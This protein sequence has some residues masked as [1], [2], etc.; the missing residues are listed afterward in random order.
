MEE[1]DKKLLQI[2]SR[3]IK[4]ARKNIGISQLELANRC[5]KSQSYIGEIEGCKKFPS[6]K[7]L[8][9]LAEHLGIKPYILLLDENDR[10]SNDKEYLLRKIKEKLGDKIDQSIDDVLGDF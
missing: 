7:T 10:I 1:R 4:E 2:V 8:N 5:G 6:L 3:N 9:L